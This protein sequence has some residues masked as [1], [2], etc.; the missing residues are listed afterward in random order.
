MFRMFWI[1]FWR[2]GKQSIG[3]RGM[4]I[5]DTELGFARMGRLSAWW[6]ECLVALV[7]EGVLALGLCER[8]ECDSERWI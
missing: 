7:S 4:R 8:A 2:E 1:G 5:L 3:F 6:W